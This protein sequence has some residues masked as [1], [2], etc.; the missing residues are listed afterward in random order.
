MNS[1]SKHTD[2]IKEGDGNKIY[3]TVSGRRHANKFFADNKGVSGVRKITGISRN[4]LTTIKLHGECAPETWERLFD[5][6][7]AHFVKP[8]QEAA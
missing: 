8:V 5:Y 1:E 6:I 7:K 3:L 4:T 2:Y